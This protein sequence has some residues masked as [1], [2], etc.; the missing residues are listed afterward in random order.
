MVRIA[1][2]VERDPFDE[3]RGVAGDYLAENIERLA[4]RMLLVDNERQS[5]AVSE[6]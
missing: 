4:G 1:R 3:N 5:A 6:G 2:E